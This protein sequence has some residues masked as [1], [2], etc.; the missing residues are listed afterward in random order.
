MTLFVF[1][2]IKNMGGLTLLALG[3]WVSSDGA[4]LLQILRPFS[5]QSTQVVNVGFF[6]IVI[7]AALVLLGILGCYAAHK[8]SK[9]LLLTFASIMLIIFISEVAT[10]VVALTYTSFVSFHFL[11]PSFFSLKD[12]YVDNPLHIFS[13]G[14]NNTRMSSFFQLHC[15][16]FSNYTD[17][18]GSNFQNATGGSLP[19]ICCRTNNNTC[20]PAQAEYSNVQGCF[21]QILMIIKENASTMGGTAAGIGLL[22]VKTHAKLKDAFKTCLC[23]S[24]WTL[25]LLFLQIAAILVS[26]NL[27]CHLDNEDS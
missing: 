3:I 8:K 24:V 14:M 17:F 5:K 11:H 21:Q 15:C 22:E 6:C 16:G 2:N 26:I 7:G 18:M 9:C 25:T 19:S 13:C 1:S 27:Y 10:G 20:T 12:H 4:S 23:H